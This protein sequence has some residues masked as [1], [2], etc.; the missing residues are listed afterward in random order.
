MNKLLIF[1]FL[2]SCNTAF[3]QAITGVLINSKNNQPIEYANIGI[4]GEN[5]GTVSNEKGKFNFFVDSIYDNDTVQFSVIGFKSLRIKIV[6]LRKLSDKEIFLEEKAYELAEVIIKPKKIKERTLGVTTK[7]K[8]IVAG[9]KDNSLGYECG[10]LMNN[11]KTA[12]LKEVNINISHCTYDT[13]FYRLNIYKVHG[14]KDFENILLEPIYIK[15]PRKSLTDLIQIDLQSQNIVVDGDFLITLEHVKDLG[16]GYLYFCAG[17][18]HKTYFRKT[19]QG[20]WESAPI[21]ISISVI[22]DVEK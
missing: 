21:G 3:G 10:I 8:R 1:I 9:F 2:I 14:K 15:M 22:A 13:V 19:S 6:D 16:A 12:H 4:V 11:K 5:V 7:F 18:G 17:V 20:K